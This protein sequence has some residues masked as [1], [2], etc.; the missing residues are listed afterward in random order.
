MHADRARL[1]APFDALKGLR[2]ELSLRE[3]VPAERV[4]LS[5]DQLELL[6]RLFHALH[7]GD[8]IRVVCFRDGCYE[9]VTGKISAISGKDRF[10]TIVKRKIAFDDIYDAKLLES[11][12]RPDR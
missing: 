8:I 10:V 4:E 5:E 12:P 1:F 2:K 7:P 6:D 3:K 9:K 11:A